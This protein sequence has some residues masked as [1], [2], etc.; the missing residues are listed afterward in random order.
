M[1]AHRLES[2]DTK[3]TEIRDLGQV[4]HF[5]AWINCDISYAEL[6]RYMSLYWLFIL[7]FTFKIIF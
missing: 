1:L 7:T 2:I 3:V 6:K 5:N 4:D